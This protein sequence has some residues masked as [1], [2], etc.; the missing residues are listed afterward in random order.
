[1][2]IEEKSKLWLKSNL[3][4]DADKETIRNASKEDLLDM[5]YKD[6]EFGTAG[7]RGV[8]GPGSNRMNTLT[9][10]KA[11]VGFAQ[12]LLKTFGEKAKTMGVVLSVHNCFRRVFV[13]LIPSISFDDS[14]LCTFAISI[15]LS[16]STG[17]C[18]KYNS[19][20]PLN[21]CICATKPN[22]SLSHFRSFSFV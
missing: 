13:V 21:S 19:C 10:R 15:N 4:S 22:I 9:V 6:M 7:M 14:V 5:F 1:M 3:V 18:F 2:N 12:Y 8:I 17:F 11:T 16:S 20:R